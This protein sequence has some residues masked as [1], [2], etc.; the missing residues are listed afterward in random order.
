MGAS[1]PAPSSVLVVTINSNFYDPASYSTDLHLLG[2][3]I[4]SS[5]SKSQNLVSSST[6]TVEHK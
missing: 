6:L 1:V 2:Q 5:Q 3:E 4:S